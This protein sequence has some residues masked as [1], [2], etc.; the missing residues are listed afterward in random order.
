MLTWLTLRR[1]P[2]E[3]RIRLD[4][5]IKQMNEMQEPFM[6]AGGAGDILVV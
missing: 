6:K 5:V 3:V 4:R 2:E 1:S